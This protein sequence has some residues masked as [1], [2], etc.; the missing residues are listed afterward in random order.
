MNYQIP[1]PALG[2]DMDEG[3]LVSWKIAVGDH[4]SRG[5]IIAVVE[6][7]K[8]AVEIESFKS[9][10]VL[11]LMVQPQEIVQVGKPIAEIQLDQTESLRAVDE[12][13]KSP[14][15]KKVLAPS[16]LA[17]A[18]AMSKS[19]REIPHFYLRKTIPVELLVSEIDRFNSSV[20]AK[21]RILFISAY[22]K[23]TS[24]ALHFFKDFNSY[25][26]NGELLLNENHNI[27]IAIR[28]DGNIS[29]IGPANEVE[30]WINQQKISFSSTKDC[31]NLIA[32]PG[33]V[34]AHTHTLFAG[35]RSK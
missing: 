33:L 34:D 27:S 4:I 17:I 35:N 7:Q 16:R 22:I 31:S 23:A 10:T 30:E 29:K 20:D 21:K 5:D 1:M 3:K 25:F 8:A 24:L 9:G 15:E 11:G 28:E 6:T 32:I 19:K 2:A 13:R 26:S 18:Q 14:G 12:K